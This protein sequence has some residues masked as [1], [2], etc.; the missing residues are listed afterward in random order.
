M[1]K[2]KEEGKE[3]AREGKKESRQT[4]RLSYVV[5]ILKWDEKESKK[6]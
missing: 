2:P 6:N 4:E 3:G 1:A 5:Q